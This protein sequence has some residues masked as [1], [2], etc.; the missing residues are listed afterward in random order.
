MP[1]FDAEVTVLAARF[2]PAQVTPPAGL[3]NIRR[4]TGDLPLRITVLPL[5]LVFLDTGA[6]VTGNS[7]RDG[8]HRFLVRFYLDVVRPRDRGRQELQLRKWL[9][10]LVDQLKT[11]GGIQLAG[12]AAQALVMDWRVGDIDYGAQTYVGIELG[13]N[14]T[15]AEGWVP[16]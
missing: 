15:T 16:S 1:D 5:V 9:T 13:V 7:S 10:V 2:A 3:P 12:A 8:L 14:V 4:S 6:F 11:G